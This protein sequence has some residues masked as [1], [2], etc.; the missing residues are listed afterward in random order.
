MKTSLDTHSLYN[1][2]IIKPVV[3]ILD[4]KQIKKVCIIFRDI[5]NML[6]N[7]L[8]GPSDVDDPPVPSGADD[9][10]GP[11]GVLPEP[12]SGIQE[13][14]GPSGASE[15]SVGS[16]PGSA[17]DDPTI[18]PIRK[19][20][21]RISSEKEGG[22][23]Y[24]RITMALLYFI[25]K[26][27]RPFHII[28]GEGFKNLMKEVAPFYK[29]P[30]AT[31]IKKKLAEKYEVTSL[32]FKQR[33]LNAEWVCVTCDIWTET[34][35]E[36]G[37]LGL[38]VHF[39]EGTS[40]CSRDI[41]VTELKTNHT[42]EYIFDRMRFILSNWNVPISKVRC[43][44]ADNGANMVAGIRLLVGESNYLPCFAHTINLISE[45]TL[46]DDVIK[47]IINKVR[48]IVKFIKNSVNNSDKLRKIQIDSGASEGSVKKL[49]LD[50]ST[51]WNSVFYMIERFLLMVRPVTIILIDNSNAPD[52]PSPQEIEILKQLLPILRPLEY[53]TK[54][55]SGERY[56]TISSVIPMLNCL[57]KQIN[58]VQ[59]ANDI[60]KQVKT[61]LLKEI[62]KRF[63]KIEFNSNVAIATLLDPRFKALHFQNAT[64]CGIAIQKL[65]QLVK[66]TTP[67]SSDGGA[68][69]G[70]DSDDDS[71]NKEYDF[72][73]IHK[74][75]AM[76]QRNRKR[77]TNDDEVTLY[78]SNSVSY[79]KS[80]PLKEWEEMK[81]MF[82]MLYKQ[83]RQFLV[84]VATSVPCER[85]FSK[86]GAIMTKNRN[87]LTSKHLDKLLFLGGCSH[88]EFFA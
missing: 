82:P 76:G 64:A 71:T 12:N 60:V 86:A 2:D 66:S 53:V 47:V 7:S 61:T 51:R 83:A 37:F 65:K 24:I 25:C 52:M 67:S 63:A 46:K 9:L 1:I 84:V 78:L 3:E 54:E 55:A 68:G 17:S 13:L 77:A 40:M 10:P 50:V 20:F 31:F 33:L 48:N 85:L 88:E 35:A 5:S 42:G 14:P 4:W 11:S 59:T 69:T 62:D 36:K 79:L 87:R 39:L 41:G 38:T 21:R 58:L 56:V 44:V 32:L 73:E 8:P 57:V 43:V 6:R 72:W 27:L 19:A 49:I 26:D 45:A 15:S 28:E 34:M 75:L 80:S 29:V 18:S 30:S 74:Q 22:L 23:R 81:L 70:G 16:L